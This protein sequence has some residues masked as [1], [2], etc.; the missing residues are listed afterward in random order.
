MIADAL[1]VVTKPDCALGYGRIICNQI[2]DAQASPGSA[3]IK[4]I[5]S[6]L[7]KLPA[8]PAV[9][10]P[11]TLVRSLPAAKSNASRKT[12]AR[13]LHPSLARKDVPEARLS[14]FANTAA[15]CPSTIRRYWSRHRLYRCR[16]SPEDSQH[17]CKRRHRRR[18]DF[19][20]LPDIQSAGI[21]LMASMPLPTPTAYRRHRR[22]PRPSQCPHLIAEHVPTGIN[23]TGG[24]S[25]HCITQPLR[26]GP[27]VIHQDHQQLI[28]VGSGG[29]IEAI[30][31]P[32]DPF[33]K[34][35]PR[36]PAQILGD[37]G[38]IAVVVL[39][40]NRLGGLR[41]NERGRSCHRHEARSSS[42]P[43]LER[44]D[45]RTAQVVDVTVRDVIGPHVQKGRQRSH[46][47][48]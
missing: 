20:A 48:S 42:L 26:L 39:N 7:P 32:L 1:T 11:D 44:D 3:W 31:C 14:Y 15:H 21:F 36:M 25:M 47:H 16:A 41:G 29:L 17:R 22:R 18:N 9:R 43:V 23:Q 24:Y 37:E 27:E 10:L 5:C 46:P 19:I 4:A 45:F 12:P 30:E 28:P 33:P 6:R 34:T 38:E 2:R 35:H 8:T 40:V 13:R